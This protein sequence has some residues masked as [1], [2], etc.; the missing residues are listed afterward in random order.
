MAEIVSGALDEYIRVNT[1]FIPVAQLLMASVWEKARPKFELTGMPTRT[2]AQVFG[3]DLVPAIDLIRRIHIPFYDSDQLDVLTWAVNWV[4]ENRKEFDKV[5]IGGGGYEKIPVQ[6]LLFYHTLGYMTAFGDGVGVKDAKEYRVPVAFGPD[7]PDFEKDIRRLTL[8]EYDRF[9]LMGL[10]MN[11]KANSS[12][13]N[14][15]SRILYLMTRFFWSGGE[16]EYALEAA[17]LVTMN[18]FGSYFLSLK[19][20]YRAISIFFR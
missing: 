5:G 19:S 7:D 12:E 11:K 18:I 4:R 17:D 9:R 14:S 2:L 8:P 15:T 13:A 10:A 1:D 20:R 6:V 3:E 16:D